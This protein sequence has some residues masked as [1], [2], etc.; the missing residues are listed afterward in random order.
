MPKREKRTFLEF[1]YELLDEDKIDD[2]LD[3]VQFLRENQLVK[4]SQLSK[5]K[6]T[7]YSRMVHYTKELSGKICALNLTG[8]QSYKPDGSWSISPHNLFFRDYNEYI[9]DEKL[10]A[11]ILNSIKIKKCPGCDGSRCN[12]AR[13]DWVRNDLTIFGENF[14]DICN[15]KF[16]NPSGEALELAKELVLITKNIIAD[17]LARNIGE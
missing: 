3:F 1:A 10:K 7:S 11:F 15:I 9:T 5:T 6:A 4:E 13:A 12:V 17:K 2:F 8:I 14:N 16:I